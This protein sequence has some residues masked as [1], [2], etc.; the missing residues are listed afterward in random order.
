MEGS[1]HDLTMTTVLPWAT[2]PL[3][4]LWKVIRSCV[5]FLWKTLD[6]FYWSQTVLH[7]PGSLT[8]W[9]SL[10]EGG[11]ADRFG[12]FNLPG[13]SSRC[14]GCGFLL[15]V[16]CISWHLRSG[17]DGND[18][19]NFPWDSSWEAAS[20]FILEIRRNILEMSR[21]D[22]EISEEHELLQERSQMKA[23]SVFWSRLTASSAT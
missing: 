19:P 7:G 21:T 13:P 2:W 1:V 3:V 22:L 14:V 15:S 12:L 4:P 18:V 9:G 23:E 11:E 10:R 8:R 20:T 6:G 5:V 17:G 16:S